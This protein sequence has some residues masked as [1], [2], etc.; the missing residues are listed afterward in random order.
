LLSE[1]H[2]EAIRSA[3]QSEERAN[4]CAIVIAGM[5]RSGT[6]A[7]TRV[8]SLLGAALPKQL[9]PAS[10]SNEAG[11]W[12]SM[13][14]M[15]IHDSILNSIGL[16]WH[17]WRPIE[18]QWF[19]SEDAIAFQAQIATLLREEY[20]EAQLFVV[21][22]PRICRLLPLWLNVFQEMGIA[23]HVVI[24]VRN[25]IEVTRSLLTRDQS[26]NEL[27]E[28]KSAQAYLLWL[29]SALDVELASRS[30][31]R[32]F[33]TYDTLLENW[34]SVV[35]TIASRVGLSWS[36]P[37]EAA[38][39]EIE[40]FLSQR[41]RHHAVTPDELEKDSDLTPWVNQAYS[42]LL[43]LAQNGD[44]AQQFAELDDIRSSLDKSLR[45]FSPL[46]K[47][48]EIRVANGRQVV[49]Q[50]RQHEQQLLKELESVRSEYQSNSQ[51]LHDFS[52]TLQLANTKVEDLKQQLDKC[53]EK[54]KHI[55]SHV[56]KLS[57]EIVELKESTAAAD[58]QGNRID[59][60][61]LDE[62][63]TLASE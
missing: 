57:A 18:E 63:R 46:L 38:L 44:D 20:G 30:I 4:R 6:S 58:P 24:P 12:E 3:A 31:P 60:G 33:I 54:I 62:V 23:P 55:T 32:A 51:I 16:M 9:M 50:L 26:R 19:K 28:P 52:S 25:P 45:T 13:P 1:R 14:M 34:Q 22:D 61:P 17:D 29:R 10:E 41:L 27:R 42:V 56:E 5:H 11:H 49:D 36:R 59:A 15:E 37:T 48:A 35:S 53:M 39:S 8:V 7:L 40:E 21:K 47:N 2:R 43:K